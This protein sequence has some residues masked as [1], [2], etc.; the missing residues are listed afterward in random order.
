MRIRTTLPG[1]KHALQL[2]HEAAGEVG[3]A[4]GCRAS[5]WRHG[6]RSFQAWFFR[7]R[8]SRRRSCHEVSRSLDFDKASLGEPDCLRGE[9][10]LRTDVG[11]GKT[12]VV[13]GL[14]YGASRASAHEAQSAYHLITSIRAR[15]PRR[16]PDSAAPTNLC[17]LGMF[18]ED[19]LSDSTGNGGVDIVVECTGNA[20]ALDRYID[21]QASFDSF[22]VGYH[23]GGPLRRSPDAE[24]ESR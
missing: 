4:L 1:R 3:I 8:R 19:L 18:R 12:I 17:L 11:L 15:K 6:D 13:I 22:I 2:G 9:R 20:Q 7:I 14:G 16:L 21:A 24:L 10:A 23:Q 5:R